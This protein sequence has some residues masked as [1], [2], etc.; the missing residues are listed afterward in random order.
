MEVRPQLDLTGWLLAHLSQP[1]LPDLECRGVKSK[2]LPSAHSLAALPAA[3]VQVAHKSDFQDSARGPPQL[4]LGRKCCERQSFTRNVKHV[5]HTSK[6]FSCS[7]I[8]A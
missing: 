4:G 7:S 1:I 2:G 8:S 5:K 3:L 6:P